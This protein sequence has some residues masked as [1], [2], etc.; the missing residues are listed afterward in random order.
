MTKAQKFLLL[1]RWR[2]E[3]TKMKRVAV[4]KIIG[5]AVLVGF[6]ILLVL[7]CDFRSSEKARFVATQTTI[8]VLVSA[9]TRFKNDCGQYPTDLQGLNVLLVS[10][11]ITNWHGPYINIECHNDS[12]GTPF[13]YTLSNG[14]PTIASAGP[15]CKFGTEDDISES[16]K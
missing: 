5:L 3:T 14:V 11:G 1:H 2:K 16:L 13:F 4:I 12:W 15:D 7:P 6:L 8:H 10:P 9:T